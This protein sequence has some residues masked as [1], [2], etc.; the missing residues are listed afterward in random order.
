MFELTPFAHHHFLNFYEPFMSTEDFEK[1]FFGH[2][3]PAF[4]TDIR[5]TGNAYILD[6]ELPGFKREDIH[7]E[8]RNGYLIIHA[9]RKT[10][11]EEKGKKNNYL[12]KERSFGSF[13]RSFPLDGI[14]ADEISASYRDGVL[15]LTLPKVMQEVEEGRRIEIQ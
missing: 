6:A 9:Q 1:S 3:F 8:V 7:A 5:E 11:N 15:T 10:E 14:N 12:K 13:I 2:Q 4:K